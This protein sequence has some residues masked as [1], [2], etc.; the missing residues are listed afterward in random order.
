MQCGTLGSRF[1]TVE[2]LLTEIRDQLTSTL[3]DIEDT[4][5]KGGDSMSSNEKGKW[6]AFF[7]RLDKAINGELKFKIAL[8]DPLANSYVQDLCAP[9]ADPQ[10]TVEEYERTEEEEDDLGLKDMK[11]EGYENDVEENKE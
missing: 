3:F 9:A 4:A 10:L 7:A 2:G 6:D 1:T 5:R 8:V 11:T